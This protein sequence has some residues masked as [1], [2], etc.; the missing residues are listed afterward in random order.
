[1]TKDTSAE[2]HLLAPALFREATIRYLEGSPD[3]PEKIREQLEA[4]YTEQLGTSAPKGIAKWARSEGKRLLGEDDEP[5]AV[6][7]AREYARLLAD[8]K[9]DDLPT[10]VRKRATELANKIA[11]MLKLAQRTVEQEQIVEEL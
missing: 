1:L 3:A 2:D 4:S 8:T 7:I 6:G 10:S 5:S 9:A 11:E